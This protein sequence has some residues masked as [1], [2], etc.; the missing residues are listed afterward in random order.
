MICDP[1]DRVVG[2]GVGRRPSTLPTD[3]DAASMEG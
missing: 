2:H 3:R 1:C